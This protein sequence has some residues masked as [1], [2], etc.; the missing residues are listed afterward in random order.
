LALARFEIEQYELHCATY[1]VEARSA[2]EAIQ[3]LFNGD[4]NPHCGSEFIDACKEVGIAVADAPNLVDELRK[5]G[6]E[7]A[8]SIIPSIRAVRRIEADAEPRPHLQRFVS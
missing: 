5:R 3:K 1:E 8:N 6:V 4:G 2:A 7:L